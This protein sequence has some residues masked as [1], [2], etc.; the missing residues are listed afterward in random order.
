MLDSSMAAFV[1]QNPVLEEVIEDSVAY[2]DASKK[3]TKVPFV[4][5]VPR[6]LWLKGLFASKRITSSLSRSSPFSK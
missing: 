6:R 4:G 2:D 3:L 5:R 1:E